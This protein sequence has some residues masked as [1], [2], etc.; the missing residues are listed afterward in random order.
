M[1]TQTAAARTTINVTSFQR[2]LLSIN[3]PPEVCALENTQI[4]RI[5]R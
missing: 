3:E 1:R 5:R 4:G 2:K